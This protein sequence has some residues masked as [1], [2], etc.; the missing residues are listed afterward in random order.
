M[1]NKQG[2]YPKIGQVV[3]TEAF[4][5]S[6][7]GGFTAPTVTPNMT[8]FQALTGMTDAGQLLIKSGDTLYAIPV[9]T[10]A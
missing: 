1:V 3:D 9:L 6:D 10:N 4:D 8:A 2:F 5:V 7:L